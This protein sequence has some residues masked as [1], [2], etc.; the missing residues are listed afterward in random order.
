[1]S[2]AVGADIE[3]MCSKC[4]DVWHVVVAKVGDKIAKVQ[5]KEC[6]GYHRYRTGAAAKAR[7]PTTGTRKK[8][9]GTATTAS[10]RIDQPRVDADL[11]RSVRSYNFRDRFEPGER[12]DHPSFG[13]GIV[14]AIPAPGKM[15][16]FFPSGRR[17]LAQAKPEPTLGRPKPFAHESRSGSSDAPE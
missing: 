9:A 3:S 17:V 15:E 16:V 2:V 8:A 5:C 4:G 11:S 7:M 14:E 12:I 6:G 13:T 10:A 1:M